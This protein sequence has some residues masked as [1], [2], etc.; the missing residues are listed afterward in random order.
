MGND[1]LWSNVDFEKEVFSHW[2]IKRLLAWCL[3]FLSESTQIRPTRVFFFL[4]SFSRNFDDQLSQY[5]GL[6]CYAYVGIHQLRRLVFDNYQTS[7]VP[8][9]PK[10]TVS[11]ECVRVIHFKW[12]VQLEWMTCPDSG[13]VHCWHRSKISIAKEVFVCNRSS[14]YE[15][16]NMVDKNKV[17]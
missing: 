1:S 12:F 5:W 4:S 11:I 3:L 15:P 8:L 9:K 6:L 10:E 16:I 7:S 14:H 2:N 13:C 17:L